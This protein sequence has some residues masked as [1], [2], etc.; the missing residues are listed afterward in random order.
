MSETMS[1]EGA[2]LALYRDAPDWDGAA[3]TMAAGKFK[4]ESAEAGAALLGAAAETAKA[5]GAA[6]LIGPMD[7]DTWHSYRVVTQ[8]VD[9]PPF[10]LE[11]TSG[12]HDLAAFRQAGFAPIAKY[13]S[14]SVPLP[15]VP[16][17]RPGKTD[18]FTIEPWDGQDAEAL[19]AQV[20]AL[21]CTAFARNAFY[22]P[23]GLDAFLTM[24]MP[25][26][27]LLKKELIFFARTAS[28]E[29][30]GFLFGVP[31]YAEGPAPRAA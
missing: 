5:E 31:N 29:L 9:V 13:C 23:I 14:A 7:G 3:P 8:S 12:P 28:G 27:P 1:N 24:Y 6:G 17:A 11:P 30:V 26:V 18:A 25:I 22:K 4:C 10:L 19:F 20:H 21:S 2:S 15:D 16:P